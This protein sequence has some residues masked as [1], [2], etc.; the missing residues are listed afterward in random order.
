MEPAIEVNG[1]IPVITSAASYD[2]VLQ[3]QIAINALSLYTESNLLLFYFT[4][5]VPTQIGELYKTTDFTTLAISGRLL[6]LG[7]SMLGSMRTNAEQTFEALFA[8]VLKVFWTICNHHS[9]IF[10]AF[11]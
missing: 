7:P 10:D 11:F 9:Q 8:R 4:V 5:R 2:G 6:L 1:K 3:A